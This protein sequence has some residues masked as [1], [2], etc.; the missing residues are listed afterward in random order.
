MKRFYK[1]AAVVDTPAGHEIHLD[2][3]PVKTP[4]RQPLR[5]PTRALADA[6][7][8][9]WEAQ[10]ETIDPRSM[11]LTGLANAA[12]DRVLPDPARFAGNIAAYAETDLTC[13]RA[14]DPPELVARQAERWNPLLDWARHRYDIHFEIVAGIMHRPQPP[15]TIARLREAVVTRDAFSL[16]G[17]SPLTTI[18]GSLIAAL[19]VAEGAIPAEQAFDVTH[20]EEIWQVEQW[21]EDYLAQEIRDARRRDF[22]AAAHCIELVSHHDDCS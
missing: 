6:V 17:L 14:E 18:G 13:Y 9:E 7:A 2:G 16:A 22:L 12:I 4:A 1:L 3:R 21:G 11:L 20:L 15:A 19:A 8:G 10:G 5:L